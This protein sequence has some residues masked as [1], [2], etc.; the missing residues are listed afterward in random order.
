M[1]ESTKIAPPACSDAPIWNAWLS[2][3]HAPA[4]AIADELGVFG[5]LEGQ[6]ATARE[7][8]VR[9]GLEPR[10][11]E[12][13]TGVLVVLD[14]LAQIDGKLCVTETGRTYLLPDS[15]YYWGP[16]LR[17]IRETP[18]DCRKLLGSLRQ[19]TAPAEARVTAMWRAPTPPPPQVLADFTHAM[20]AHSFAL[21]MRTVPSCGFGGAVRVL[22]VGGGSGS[23]SIA[24]ALHE[25]SLQCMILDLPP[26]CE[27]AAEYAR[28]L[29]VAG[30]VVPVPADMFEDPWPGGCDRI[31]FSDIFH[32]W[33]DD[34][35]HW[36][37]RRAHDVLPPGGRVLVHE[38]VL[39]D[40]GAGPLSAAS[41]SMV[42]LF[43][44][45]GR[46]RS[47]RE[48]GQILSSAGFSSISGAPTSG[49]YAMISATKA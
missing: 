47:A 11:T 35:C 30:R 46:Q 31:F 25:P 15:P 6:P 32:D 3:F 44:A 19:G 43:V 9:L 10:A 14:L 40:G 36:L 20:H 39:S 8:A 29:G 22:D 23:Y 1:A 38:M 42:M 37:A 28:K 26:V 7:L 49:G 33:D 45:Q 13:I 24:A 2:A 5:A 21:A 41:Y 17:R 16:L 27:V 18:L 4:L 34:R 48:L 12:A